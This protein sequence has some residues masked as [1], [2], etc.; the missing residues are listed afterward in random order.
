M[1]L[2]ANS[3]EMQELLESNEAFRQSYEGLCKQFEKRVVVWTPQVC[4]LAKVCFQD[5][6]R[7]YA[8][9]VMVEVRPSIDSSGRF[10]IHFL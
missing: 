6:F 8:I 3:K 7:A 5:M 2:V 1:S 4:H 10:F 9:N